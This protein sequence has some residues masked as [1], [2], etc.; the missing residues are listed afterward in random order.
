MSYRHNV[1][2]H[3][4][5]LGNAGP[6]GPEATTVT[7]GTTGA[8]GP[9]GPTGASGATGATGSSVKSLS[10]SVT[11]D[12]KY[13]IIVEY[14]NGA[15]VDAG[16]FRGNTG[17]TKFWLDGKN[18]GNLGAGS[19]FSSSDN[20]E[21]KLKGITGGGGVEVIDA[22]NEI[23]IRYKTQN[24]M[25]ASGKTGQLAFFNISSG[26]ATGLSG[27]TLTQFHYDSTNSL[28]FVT[29][30]NT[31]TIGRL[32]ATEVD[33]D[34]HTMLY[35]INPYSMLSLDGA[36][37]QTALGNT[38][39]IRPNV[40]TSDLGK[41]PS[42]FN[43]Y[44]FRILDT[45]TPLDLSYSY[46]FSNQ[47][48]AHFTIMIDDYT[49]FDSPR[50]NESGQTVNYSHLMFPENWILPRGSNPIK[51]RVRSVTF[52]TFGEK[53]PRTEKTAWYGVINRSV[54]NPFV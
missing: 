3:P 39:F 52:Y 38:I 21:L 15:T 28:D 12:K 26:G 36:R 34:T 25:T 29:Y 31:E 13:H 19:L 4:L 8:L 42:Q 23:L 33:P 54:G 53:D 22:G 1:S 11:G 24:G 49:T 10:Y 20:G 37:K 44:Y 48:F 16:Q 43:P 17:G 2:A 18:I 46:Y 45:T 7:T 27:A 6:K 14:D 50:I 5:I 30:R 32:R 41:P 35:N 9:T 47:T 40:D 51:D